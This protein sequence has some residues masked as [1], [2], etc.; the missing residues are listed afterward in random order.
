MRRPAR[1]FGRPHEQL[2]ADLDHDLGHVHRPA[3]QVDPAAAQPGQL[4]DAQAAV[5]ADQDQRPVALTDGVGQLGDLGRVKDRISSR[6]T[7]GSRT[8]RHGDRGTMSAFTAAVRV[9]P[10]SW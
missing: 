6:S 10:R 5:G 9:R 2:A 4:P 7:L 3:Q 8:V 1:V